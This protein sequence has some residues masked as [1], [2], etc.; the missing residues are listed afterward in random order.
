MIVVDTN[1]VAYFSIQGTQTSVARTVREI[2]T[3]WYLPP[4]WRHEYLN[5]LA[6]L[7]RTGGAELGEVLDLWEST[8]RFFRSSERDPDMDLALRLSIE[9]SVSAYDAQYAA[10]ALKLGAPLIT[11]DRK[12]LKAF[13]DQ[14]LSMEAFSV[15]KQ[16]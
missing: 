14:A 9:R 8:T 13:P 12:L 1:V 11:E 3:D 16:I 7:A 4:L 10:L 5:L 2:D 6:T 15:S